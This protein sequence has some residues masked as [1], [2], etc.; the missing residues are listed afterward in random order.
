MK[1]IL[2]IAL[3]LILMCGM[4]SAFDPL[5]LQ[6]KIMTF[7]KKLKDYDAASSYYVKLS[8]TGLGAGMAGTGYKAVLKNGA[9]VYLD[10]ILWYIPADEF[11]VKFFIPKKCYED[12]DGEDCGQTMGQM[13]EL[14]A[15]EKKTINSDYGKFEMNLLQFWIDYTKDLSKCDKYN[16]VLQGVY[17]ENSGSSSQTSTGNIC[18]VLESGQYKKGS[19][20]LYN[21]NTA[22]AIL[23]ITELN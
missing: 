13:V 10:S 3:V 22:Y 9:K 17:S 7:S 20:I 6:K 14:K 23:K 4:V 2:G 12:L 18:G 16:S 11:I 8:G 21:N 1:K 5:A 19:S 15:Y